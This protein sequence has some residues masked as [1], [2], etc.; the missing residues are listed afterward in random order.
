MLLA[1]ITISSCASKAS[2]TV[3][4]VSD[5]VSKIQI[6]ATTNPMTLTRGVEI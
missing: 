2:Y 4:S 6:I 1:I 5:S 3:P